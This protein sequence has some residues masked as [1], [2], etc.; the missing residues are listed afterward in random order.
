MS[1]VRKKVLDQP[2][3]LLLFI[4]HT[5]KWWGMDIQKV[6][7]EKYWLKCPLPNHFMPQNKTQRANSC[8]VAMN[9]FK[10]RRLCIV[11]TPSQCW[12][13]HKWQKQPQRS[14]LEQNEKWQP[15]RTAQ[16]Q[17][18]HQNWL[19]RAVRELKLG[20][21]LL[22]I[23]LT[24]RSLF[25]WRGLYP[26]PQCCFSPPAAHNQCRNWFLIPPLWAIHHLFTFR[27]LQKCL[28]LTLEYGSGKLNS[29][30]QCSLVSKRLLT[31]KVPYALLKGRRGE[32]RNQLLQTE[33]VIFPS[34]SSVSRRGNQV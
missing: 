3:A 21:F 20:I 33:K 28:E 25:R 32:R 7:F 14:E 34:V 24:R 26:T 8:T 18:C 15:P 1:T 12:A 10:S 16:G 23:I 19:L 17:G 2:L 11:S 4:C 31:V 27:V 30:K 29:F 9:V 22:I 6:V 5:N 13:S